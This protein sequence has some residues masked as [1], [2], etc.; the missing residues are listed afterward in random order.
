MG[1]GP[2]PSLNDIFNLHEHIDGL[3]QVELDFDVVLGD[4]S[5]LDGIG[6]AHDCTELQLHLV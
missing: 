4:N 2:G 6:V 3:A 1:N 5:S